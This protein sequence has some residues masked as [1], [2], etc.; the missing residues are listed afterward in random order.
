M[1]DSLE[2]RTFVV[3]ALPCPETN[4]TPSIF[5]RDAVPLALPAEYDHGFN[6]HFQANFLSIREILDPQS[7]TIPTLF[8]ETFLDDADYSLISRGDFYKQLDEITFGRNVQTSQDSLKSGVMD[9]NCDPGLKSECAHTH[10][11]KFTEYQKVTDIDNYLQKERRLD[12][13]NLKPVL[14][15]QVLRWTHNLL[16]IADTTI[17][18]QLD[19]ILLDSG[20][21]YDVGTL[22]FRNPSKLPSEFIQKQLTSITTWKDIQIDYKTAP[23][24]FCVAVSDM[25]S[26]SRPKA[27]LPYVSP[28]AFSQIQN[29][30]PQWA[31]WC[32]VAMEAADAAA[33]IP[34]DCSLL[35]DD[36]MPE[37]PAECYT[38]HEA[39]MMREGSR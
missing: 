33:K 37:F 17:D 4:G 15:F 9:A 8:M 27:L 39:R 6:F 26:H 30:S 7:Q 24:K 16:K 3:C 32:Q 18:I 21:F 11:P 12:G 25:Q 36:E 2:P 10:A 1:T 14:N 20:K 19:S 29:Y 13:T 34:V 22:R 35:T 28:Y 23:T 5:L 31:R 38:A